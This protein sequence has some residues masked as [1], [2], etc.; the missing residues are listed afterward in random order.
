MSFFY[1]VR[2]KVCSVRVI[3][4]AVFFPPQALS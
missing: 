3:E 2:E 1:Y 4:R